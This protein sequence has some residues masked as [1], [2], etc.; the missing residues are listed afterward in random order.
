MPAL[1]LNLTLNATLFCKIKPSHQRENIL[2]H[3]AWSIKF[4]S[5]MQEAHTLQKIGK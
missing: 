3:K 4:K 1:G 5:C 2:A